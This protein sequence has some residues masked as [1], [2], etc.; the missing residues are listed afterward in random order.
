VEAII[1][2]SAAKFR[3]G[4]RLG[5]KGYILGFHIEIERP[6]RTVSAN[7]GVLHPTKRRC[8]MAD[9]FR[10][11]PDHPCLQRIGEAEGAVSTGPKISSCAIRIWLCAPVNSAG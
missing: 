11:R 5:G 4:V 10:V 3:N 8:Q 2:V 6:L 9:V 7:P 1:V